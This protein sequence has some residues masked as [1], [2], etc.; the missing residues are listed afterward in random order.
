MKMVWNFGSNLLRID[1]FR[2]KNGAKIN[3]ISRIVYSKY[4]R[5]RGA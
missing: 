5:I 2:E 4:V 1:L 3:Q